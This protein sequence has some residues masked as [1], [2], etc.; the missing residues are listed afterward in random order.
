MRVTLKIDYYP[1]FA[2]KKSNILVPTSNETREPLGKVKDYVW[3]LD[4]EM[5]WCY[6]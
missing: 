3:V 5:R 4:V 1:S 6:W 2:K